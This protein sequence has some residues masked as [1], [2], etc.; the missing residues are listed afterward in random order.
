MSSDDPVATINPYE[1]LG[2]A[3]NADFETIRKAYKTMALKHHP[4]KN[5]H[6][7]TS[8][9]KFQEICTSF[10]ILKDTTKRYYFDKYGT[11]DEHVISEMQQREE[12]LQRQ[13]QQN[14]RQKRNTAG[15]GGAGGYANTGM[16]A[17]ATFSEFFNFANSFGHGTT[18]PFT[19][20][21]TSFSSRFPSAFGSST[22]GFSSSDSFFNSDFFASF[23][24]TNGTSTTNTR[25]KSSSN[26]NADSANSNNRRTR[27]P[28]FGTP[29]NTAHKKGPNIL[30]NLKISLV[31]LYEGKTLKLKMSRS[32]ICETC[33]GTEASG[34]MT[35]CNH[36]DG[37]GTVTKMDF[38]SAWQ[39][40]QQAY[41]RKCDGEG[42][43]FQT[44][45][46]CKTCFGQGYVNERK[47]F[48]VEVVKGMKYSEQIVLQGQ[49]DEVIALANG[50]YQGCIPGDVV[51]TLVP[52]DESV[53]LSKVENLTQEKAVKCFVTNGG[54]DL[55]IDNMPVQLVDILCGGAIT[56][57]QNIHPK[58][59][60]TMKLQLKSN[61]M[62]DPQE[63]FVFEHLGMPL[64]PTGD[65]YGD[66]YV[67]FKVTFPHSLTTEQQ[68]QL[69]KVLSGSVS[70]EDKSNTKSNGHMESQ[71]EERQDE[72]AEDDVIE[73]YELYGMSNVIN[74]D[75]FSD[76]A[77]VT[78]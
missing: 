51:I 55:F 27:K 42:K 45:E 75:E 54:K 17:A 19:S 18:S 24:N 76:I 31:D 8:N 64:D 12:Q 3:R 63:I 33:H 37:T 34:F 57:P 9:R 14:K 49:A 39:M 15:G 7:E 47:I 16:S 4:D 22:S 25:R 28:A 56:I 13:K 21:S 78:K 59:H 44:V 23:T 40:L 68:T 26:K 29:D 5:N 1:T 46:K 10:N 53:I 36:C 11:V 50:D 73:E 67:R 48:N 62:A 69:R 60:G 35:L 74:M 2:V 72:E 65:L 20:G 30:H 66:L 77:K 6:S 61:S 70:G 32:K 38:D 43:Y 58:R 71:E 41:C 52:S